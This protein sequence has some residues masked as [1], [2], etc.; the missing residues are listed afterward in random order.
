MSAWNRKSVDSHSSSLN[1]PNL[2]IISTLLNLSSRLGCWKQG[3][4]KKI[5]I[6]LNMQIHKKTMQFLAGV[7]ILMISLYPDNKYDQLHTEFYL[8]WHAFRWLNFLHRRMISQI[9][10]AEQRAKENWIRLFSIFQLQKFSAQLICF[11]SKFTLLWPT[12]DLFN[13]N[14]KKSLNHLS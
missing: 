6:S 13:T 5:E 7:K 14:G 1:L 2:H 11:S 4:A 12:I 10:G 8:I 3:A 9:C